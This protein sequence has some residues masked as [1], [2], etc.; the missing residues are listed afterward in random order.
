MIIC[1]SLAGH[2]G[3]SLGSGVYLYNGNVQKKRE[4]GFWL[5]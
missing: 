1:R 5:L 4:R 2:C 3:C